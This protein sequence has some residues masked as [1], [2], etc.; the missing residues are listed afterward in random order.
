MR[1]LVID[2]HAIV[3]AGLCRLLASEPGIEVV[4][5]ANGREGL[6]L[7]RA[8]PPKLVVLDLNLPG[9]GGLELIRRFRADSPTVPILIFSMHSEAI[10]V[11]RLL[12]A[13]ASGF[14]S[15]NAAPAEL[16]EA[17]RRVAAGERYLERAIAQQVALMSATGSPSRLDGLSR[18]ELEILRLL[19][20]GKGLPQIAESIGISYK[21][22]ANTCGMIKTKLGVA[23]TAELIRIAI[24]SGIAGGIVPPVSE[25]EPRP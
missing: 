18:R 14:V 2:D 9:M 16:L 8:R 10:Y 12:E 17:I 21:T 22:V 23:R 6:D 7:F 3:R 1:V 15:K 20:E 24:E 4:E 25:P 5:A 11:T 13:G 19:G